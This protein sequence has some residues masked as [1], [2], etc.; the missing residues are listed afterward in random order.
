MLDMFYYARIR[1][2]NP[3]NEDTVMRTSITAERLTNKQGLIQKAINIVQDLYGFPPRVACSPFLHSW[4]GCRI[5]ES[6]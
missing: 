3:R 6:L 4:I 1:K 2:N 5:I